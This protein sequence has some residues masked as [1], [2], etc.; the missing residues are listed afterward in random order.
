M[1]HGS[2]TRRATRL[3]VRRVVWRGRLSR[4][5]RQRP[6]RGFY[7]LSW[8]EYS[9]LD[10]DRYSF[11]AVDLAAQQF[12]PIFDKKRVFA[13]QGR[14]QSA[15]TDDGAGQIVPFYFKPTLGGSTSHRG[16]NDFRFRDDAVVNVNVEYRWE[17]F[18]GLDM[19]LFSD[20]GTVAPNI[21][22]LKLVRARERLRHRVP[23]Q[24]L[25]VGLV[26]HRHRIRRRRRPAVL[27]VQQGVLNAC[28][29]TTA[30]MRAPARS[31]PRREW[32]LAVG[33]RRRR[34]SRPGR[35]SFATIRSRATP[36]PRTPAGVRPAELSELYD[37]AENSFLGAGEESDPAP[38]T[39]TRS[40]RCPTRAGSPTVLGARSWT[41]DRR[42]KG[43]TRA[44][45]H[46][47]VDHRV[48]EDGR[49]ARDSR[50]VTPPASSTSSSSI[51]LEPRDGERRRSHLDQVLPCLRLPRARELP[52]HDPPRVARHRRKHT[53]RRRQRPAAPDGQP[54]PRQLLKRGARA[55]RRQLPRPGQ[56]GARG[57]ARRAVPLLR[58]A[59]GRPERHLPAR[60]SPRAAWAARLLRLAEPRRLAQ[61]QHLDTLVSRR[62]AAPLCAITCSTSDRR[63]AAARPRRRARAPATSSCGSRGRRSS[64]CSRSASTCGR[65]SRWHYPDIPSLGRIESTY[66]RPEDWK[67]EYPNPAFT[68]ARPEDRFWAARILAGLSDD[69]VRAVV[70]T[71][72]FSDSKATEYLTDTLLARKRR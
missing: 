41:T 59:T 34:D 15:A 36:R 37:F 31:R 60:A 54:R 53:H 1:T 42:S 45:A 40:T 29:R 56:Q 24:H 49:C 25:Q 9:D 65:G 22:Q 20:W 30:C 62:V 18:S 44:P 26:P 46:G 13:V 51:R 43:R 72:Q 47:D 71:A 55:A 70:G 39:S 28:A 38:S 4:P 27:Q 14:L 33:G 66:F 6:R 10:F 64:R 16:F 11:R 48:G 67:P 57:Q 3:L 35:S 7:S 69:G 58:H 63:S 5:G 21:G 50:F 23:L 2:R 61:H 32:Q 17:A 68:N 12:V 52:R 19:A 8:R